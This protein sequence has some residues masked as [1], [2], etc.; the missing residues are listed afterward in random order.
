MLYS[1]CRANLLRMVSPKLAQRTDVIWVIS[2]HEAILLSY[3]VEK[4]KPVKKLIQ[5][6]SLKKIDLQ[7]SVTISMSAICIAPPLDMTELVSWYNS[8]LICILDEHA[9]LKSKLIFDWTDC[10]WYTNELSDLKWHK[11]KFERRHK[12]SQ[13]TIDLGLYKE[14]IVNSSLNSTLMNTL[15]KEAMINVILKKPHLLQRHIKQLSP[16]V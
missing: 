8:E 1:Q 14:A 16:C 5:Y 11:R 12:S 4:P 15:M 7:N 6:T 3:A 10:K 9:P 13:L 2:D